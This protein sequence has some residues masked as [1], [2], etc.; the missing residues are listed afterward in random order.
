MV[1]FTLTLQAGPLGQCE[2]MLLSIK[3][4]SPGMPPIVIA[5][6]AGNN[7]IPSASGD[8]HFPIAQDRVTY[9]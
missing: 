2:V 9:N 7:V 5:S 4:V 1:L 8:Q 3:G 6:G